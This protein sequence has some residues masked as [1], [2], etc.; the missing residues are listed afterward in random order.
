MLTILSV[1]LNVLYQVFNCRIEL[2][3]GILRN[4]YSL[5]EFPVLGLLVACIGR[6]RRE[7]VKDVI[8]TGLNFIHRT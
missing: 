5:E 8:I 2:L 7:V 1:Q 6:L 4:I 3:Y